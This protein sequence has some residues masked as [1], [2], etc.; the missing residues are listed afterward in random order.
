VK[1]P[2]QRAEIKNNKKA[3]RVASAQSAS[4]ESNASKMAKDE[5]KVHVVRRGENLTDIARKYNVSMRH[6]IA[7]N[8]A[9]KNHSKLYI[10]KKLTIPD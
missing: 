8:T 2:A 1:V 3:T 4:Q 9:L 7:A 10:G 6:L 5:L